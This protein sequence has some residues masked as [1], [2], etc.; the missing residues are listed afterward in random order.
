MLSDLRL[1]IAGLDPGDPSFDEAT[2]QKMTDARVKPAHDG[3]E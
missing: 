3:R 1:V 2:F